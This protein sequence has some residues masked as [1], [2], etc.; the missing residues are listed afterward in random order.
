MAGFTNGYS[1]SILDAQI[2][3]TDYVAW[4]ENGSSESANLARTAITS[5]KSAT[6][7]DPSVKGNNGVFLSAPSRSTRR[8]S[9]GA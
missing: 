7:A 2:L 8:A 4:S 5:W 3:T 6:V 9:S 1:A